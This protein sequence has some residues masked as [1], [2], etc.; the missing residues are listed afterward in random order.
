MGERGSG[1][2]IET[3]GTCTEG[4]WQSTI[5]ETAMKRPSMTLSNSMIPSLL[6]LD[7]RLHA[8]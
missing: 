7:C 2:A 5:I 1:G 3:T 6:R 4:T 8:A